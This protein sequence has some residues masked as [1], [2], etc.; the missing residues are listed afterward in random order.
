MQLAN[1]HVP[2]KAKRDGRDHARK[3]TS[4]KSLK[5]V[6]IQISKQERLKKR[7]DKVGEVDKVSQKSQIVQLELKKAFERIRGVK[8]H[9]N[10]SVLKKAEKRLVKKKTKSAENWQKRKH[11]VKQS[12]E[13]RQQ[14]RK[15]NIGKFRG[16]KARVDPAT[17]PAGTE[18]PSNQ[19]PTRKMRRHDNLMKFGPKKTRSDREDQKK[20]ARKD[21]RSSDRKHG[22]KKSAKPSKHGKPSKFGKNARK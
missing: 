7:A 16:S 9:D 3:G 5:Q 14:K 18:A 17:L 20:D 15:D 10:L 4:L 11:D 8:I 1:I 2:S 19:K 12:Q 13:D 6:R 22:G 21:R